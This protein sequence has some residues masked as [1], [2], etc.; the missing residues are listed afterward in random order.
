MY[1][2]GAASECCAT[3]RG[4]RYANEIIF[5]FGTWRWR[6]FVRLHHETRRRPVRELCTRIFPSNR[7]CHFLLPSIA[8]RAQVI[9]TRINPARVGVLNKIKFS[10]YVSICRDLKPENVVF[11]EKLGVVK[12]TDFGFSNK[13]CPGQ[14]LETSCGSLAY[15]AP[16]ILLGDSY[17]APAVGMWWPHYGQIFVS[18]SRWHL[19]F[20]GFSFGFAQIFGRWESFCTC[21][22]A[23]IRHFKR[24][25][26]RK[27][28][29]WLWIA[30]TRCQRMYRTVVGI[31]YPACLYANRTNEQHCRWLHRTSG[32]RQ[33]DLNMY[34]N[35]Y[36]WWVGN[37]S[38]K[39]I[40][41]SSFRKW[42]TE[43]S[44]AKRKSSSEFNV[45]FYSSNFV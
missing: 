24:Q 20:T 45:N 38:A 35:I 17:D 40:T 41:R 13:F 26:T 27:H 10:F 16:E 23:G 43:I 19:I 32:W 30:S 14:K 15:S 44:P 3:V 37:K 18:L 22:C 39:R 21:W 6:R 1:E 11:F 9:R 33:T 7:P 5:D 29:Q 25:T 12:L 42:W 28:W 36:R 2:T 34:L 31:W 8:R 4:D